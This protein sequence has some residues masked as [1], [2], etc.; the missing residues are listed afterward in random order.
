MS[1]AKITIQGMEDYLNYQG[2]SLFDGLTLPEG[3]NPDTLK[4][5]IFMEAGE[6]EVLYSN[7]DFMRDKITMW[8]DKYYSTF[9]KW[10]QVLL[11]EYNPL[12]NYNRHEEVTESGE[13]NRGLK[14]TAG[15][16]VNESTTNTRKDEIEGDSRTDT[17][18]EVENRVSAFDSSSYQPKDYTES[19]GTEKVDYS[20]K[21][22]IKDQGSRNTS[23]DHNIDEQEDKNFEHTKISKMYGNIGVT[24]SQQMLQAE[25]DIR[26]WNIYEHITDLFIKDFLIPVYDF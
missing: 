9:E 15:E 25:L 13:D 18:G 4:G 26:A 5:N 23:R 17:D 10:I 22:N 16:E 7:P 11:T 24:T 3:I 20:S 2:K 12:D 21:Q 6:F 1:W 14:H 8:S 19:E